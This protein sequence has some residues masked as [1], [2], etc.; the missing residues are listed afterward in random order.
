M[1][2][3][4][5]GMYVVTGGSAAISGVPVNVTIGVP[6]TVTL[7]W[8]ISPLWASAPWELRCDPTLANIGGPGSANCI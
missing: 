1:N 6:I 2:T 3:G 5:G 4:G 8:Y 7:Q